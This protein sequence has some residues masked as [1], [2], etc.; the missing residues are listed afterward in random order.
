MKKQQHQPTTLAD[1]IPNVT[2]ALRAVAVAN[3][4]FFILVFLFW[5]GLGRFLFHFESLLKAGRQTLP[6]PSLPVLYFILGFT[7][8]GV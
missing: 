3:I 7:V 1:S 8:N 5:T 2:A 4:S 6:R